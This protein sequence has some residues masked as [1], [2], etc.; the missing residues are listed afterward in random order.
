MYIEKLRLR[1]FRC[2]GDMAE[3]FTFDPTL[4]AVVGANGAGKSAIIAALMKLFGTRAEDRRLTRE[5]VHFGRFEE[6]GAALDNA[7]DALEMPEVAQPS[8]FPID[9]AELLGPPGLPPMPAVTQIS[10]RQVEIEV[11]LAFP[12]LGDAVA[13]GAAVP[14]IFRAMSAAGPGQPLKARIRLEA[15]WSYG[16]DDD[17][18][19]TRIYWITTLDAVYEAGDGGAGYQAV[20]GSNQGLKRWRS[21]PQ[22]LLRSE[23]APHVFTRPRLFSDL[24]QVRFEDGTR[25]DLD[26]PHHRTQGYLQSHSQCSGSAAQGIIGVIGQ[27]AE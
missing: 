20:D 17:D 11:T 10:E 12:E 7:L 26:I 16:A 1:N 5:D 2:F 8:A 27:H 21:A 6:P 3:E 18:I 13:A 4:T 23:P 15:S 9:L 14:E 25:R 19:S 24:E 22:C